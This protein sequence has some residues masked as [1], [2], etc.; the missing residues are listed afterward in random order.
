[1]PD[2]ELLELA[3]KACGQEYWITRLGSRTA[4]TEHLHYQ[5]GNGETEVWNPLTNDGDALRVAV[6]LNLSVCVEFD[7]TYICAHGA[8]TKPLNWVNHDCNPYEAT[9]RAIVQAAAEIGKQMGYV[10]NREKISKLALDAG[11]IDPS[12]PFNP[13]SV[14]QEGLERFVKLIE[15]ERK[16]LTDDQITLIIGECAA[17]HEHTD[18]EGEK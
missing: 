1:M 16:P 5:G 7:Q 8:E 15:A 11:F 9:R 3:A 14:S 10:M 2:K 4:I 12:H 6:K 13:W 18:K 17:R